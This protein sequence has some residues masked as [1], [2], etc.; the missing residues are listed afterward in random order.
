MNRA[1][2]IAIAA[3]FLLMLQVWVFD[4]IFLFRIATPYPYIYLLLMLPLDVS[5]SKLTLMGFIYGS[6]LDILSGSPGLHA[7]TFT[8][9]SF[10]RNYLTI[11]FL[12]KETD[13]SQA[14][15]SKN[16]RAGIYIFL[17]ELV[18]IHH[19]LLFLLDSWRA[20]KVDYVMLRCSSSILLSYTLLVIIHSL[21]GSRARSKDHD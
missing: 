16:M 7:A 21:F 9:I 13:R 8:A 5:K 12:E 2:N 18:A 17:F 20:F 14:P 10:L 19:S 4:F 3:L 11:P 6:L 15:S 1:F